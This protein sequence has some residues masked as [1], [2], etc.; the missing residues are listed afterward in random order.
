MS[1]IGLTSGFELVPEGKHV[2]VISAVNYDQ[3]F[4]RMTVT[5]KTKDGIRK[6]ERFQ[7]LDQNQEVN[8]KAMNAFSYFA[9]VATK[10][11]ANREIETDDLV[12]CFIG[13]NAIHDIQPNRND[14][15][16]TVTFVNLRDWF[17]ADAFEGET[18]I[19]PKADPIP[20]QPAKKDILA[21]LGL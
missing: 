4:G 2:F 19:P 3:Q 12:D 5:L 7:L 11:Y 16:K 21:S 10:D 15:S 20:P 6:D 1:R 17:E 13:A 18:L 14:P 8:E 9:K